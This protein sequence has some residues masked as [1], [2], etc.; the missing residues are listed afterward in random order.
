MYGGGNIGRGFVGALF[1]RSGYHVT[2]VDVAEPIVT[3]LNERKSY[4]IRILDGQNKEDLIIDCLTLTA[5]SQQSQVK[6]TVKALALIKKSLGVKTTLGISNVSFGLPNRPLL[7][8][9]FLAEY[10]RQAI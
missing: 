4:P 7:N 9:V 1:S 5:S 3:E 10:S 6:E 2:F 8:S